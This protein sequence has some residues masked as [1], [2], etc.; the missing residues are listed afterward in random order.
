MT[1]IKASNPI[2][3]IKATPD[4]REAFRERCFILF[5]FISP[6]KPANTG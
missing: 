6:S 4:L 1:I 3:M 2:T 5:K